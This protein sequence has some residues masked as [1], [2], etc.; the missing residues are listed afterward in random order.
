[1]NKDVVKIGDWVVTLTN[2]D[3]W[4]EDTN[5][6]VV[7][8]LALDGDTGEVIGTA[9]PKDIYDEEMT[10]GLADWVLKKIQTEDAKA[11]SAYGMRANAQRDIESLK[12]KALADLEKTPE[13][14]AARAQDANSER[15]LKQ[16]ERNRDF[17]IA[18]YQ[19]DLG[20][21]AAKELK[22]KKERAW[23]RPGGSVALRRVPAKL[24]VADESKAIKWA[25]DFQPDAIT[26]TFK[27]NSLAKDVLISLI[28]NPDNAEM[29]GF[30]IEPETQKV[31]IKSGIVFPEGDKA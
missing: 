31:T 21:F 20:E 1:M 22:G 7:D 26:K 9:V 25:E 13:M 27:V 12:E 8:G 14:L 2:Q 29:A 24:Q 6:E 16:A 18:K 3:P 10:V 5:I 23:Y 30:V 11:A 28:A 4:N 17:F 15:I 19:E